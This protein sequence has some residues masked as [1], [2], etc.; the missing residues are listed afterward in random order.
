MVAG[1]ALFILHL[2]R[3]APA[4]G[5]RLVLDLLG[6]REIVSTALLWAAAFIIG[7]IVWPIVEAYTSAT[8][9][10]G[11]VE[12]RSEER[13]SSRHLWYR[14]HRNHGGLEHTASGTVPVAHPYRS[15]V[16]TDLQRGRRRACGGS[17]L[18]VGTNDY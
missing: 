11:A 13:D 15:I 16:G 7:K 3:S 9:T 10:R 1:L 5:I 17:R 18:G 12:Y 6:A 14:G 8:E 2:W 4:P